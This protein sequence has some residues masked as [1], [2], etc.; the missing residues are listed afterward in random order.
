MCV[1]NY[2]AKVRLLFQTT[3][4]FF[5][6]R[7]YRRKASNPSSSG[8][9]S[10]GERSQKFYVLATAYSGSSGAAIGG[11]RNAACG[12][13]TITDGVT[14]VRAIKKDN[15]IPYSIG[16]GPNGTCGTITIGGNVTK[17][18]QDNYTYTGTG[19]GSVDTTPET[20][21]NAVPYIPVDLT[22]GETEGTWT[23]VM[24]NGDVQVSVAYKAHNPADVNR[25]GTV[26]VAD[27]ATIIDVMAKGTSAF[28]EYDA[29]VN[30]DG[31]VDVAD[32][33]SVIDVMAANARRLQNTI[34]DEE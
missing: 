10:K 11:G 31:T 12:D 13:I 25:D 20:T 18:I 21:G 27:I 30:E 28:P 22:P 23:F 24:P 2:A 9:A 14:S 33:A 15:D 1:C 3:K 19:S 26:D 34:D 6:A 32:I 4:H 7:P 29:D 16:A 17:G 5:T 8:I